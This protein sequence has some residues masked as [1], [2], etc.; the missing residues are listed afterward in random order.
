MLL[1]NLFFFCDKIH[2]YIKSDDKGVMCTARTHDS[3]CFMRADGDARPVVE[4]VHQQGA[5][6]L[7]GELL[8]N[9]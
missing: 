1:L 8:C 3:F 2:S 6:A 4:N 7:K 5:H 9:T